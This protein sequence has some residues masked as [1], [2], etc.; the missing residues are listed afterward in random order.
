MWRRTIDK[1]FKY[2]LN[3]LKKKITRFN[4][5]YFEIVKPLKA[6][7]QLYQKVVFVRFDSMG[8]DIFFHSSV[9]S[10]FLHF[11]LPLAIMY[12]TTSVVG[13]LLFRSTLLFTDDN[14]SGTTWCDK[15]L[16]AISKTSLTEDAITV[17]FFLLVFFPRS[18]T[19]RFRHQQQW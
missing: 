5:F 14:K 2:M 10:W 4:K 12:T 1:I 8:M 9:L 15:I 3:R 19:L 7:R 6:P 16:Y 18:P 13:S 11:P 17:S